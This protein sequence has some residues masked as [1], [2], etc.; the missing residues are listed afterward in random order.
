MVDAAIQAEGLEK[1]Y[2]SDG[3]G[4]LVL[5]GLDLQVPAGAFV[6]IMGPS[7]CGKSTLLHILGL[8]MRADRGRLTMLGRPVN[9]LSGRQQTEIRRCSV[10]FVFQRFN[11]LASISALSNVRLAA[12]LRGVRDKNAPADMLAQVGLDGEIGRRPA[13][14]SIGEQQRVAIARALVGR[15][16]LLLADEPTGNLDSENADRILELI[17]RLH[18]QF[19]QTTIV[20]THSASAADFADVVLHMKDGRIIQ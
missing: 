6:A 15:P 8:M 17:R 7:G 16:A 10:G 19:G 1:S 11:L 9:D 5:R 12:Q 13:Q 18:G 4:N 3:V 14:L 20:I 2:R